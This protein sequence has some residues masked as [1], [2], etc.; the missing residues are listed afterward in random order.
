VFGNSSLGRQKRRD[1]GENGA[2]E[3][4]SLRNTGLNDAHIS[5]TGVRLY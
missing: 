2:M 3:Q 1:E 4:K 5:G